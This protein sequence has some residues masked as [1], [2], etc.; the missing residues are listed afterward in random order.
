VLHGECVAIVDEREL[1]PR[2]WDLLHCPAG[3][4]HVLI[5]AGEEP[6]TVLMIGSRRRQGTHC[7]ISEAAARHDASVSSPTDEPDE[8]YADWRREP[9]QPADGVWPSG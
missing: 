3:A 5:G 6:C 8:A 7:P 9:W 4:A 1:P 2:Q